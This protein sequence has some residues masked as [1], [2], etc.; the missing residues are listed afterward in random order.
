MFQ[1]HI[2]YTWGYDLYLQVKWI[3]AIEVNRYKYDKYVNMSDKKSEWYLNM[4]D[5]NIFGYLKVCFQI[6]VFN[7]YVLSVK[8]KMIFLQ[9]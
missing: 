8:Q 1:L 6:S 2:T 3:Q 5:W 4:I 9:P 7:E